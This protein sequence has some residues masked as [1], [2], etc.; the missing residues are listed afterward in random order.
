MGLIAEPANVRRRPGAPGQPDMP[1]A[2]LFVDLVGYSSRPI[3]EQVELKLVVNGLVARA[4]SDDAPGR[5]LA[6]DTGDG[7]ALCFLGDPLDAFHATLRLRQ[8]PVGRHGL[9]LPLRMG[10][11]HGPVRLVPDVNGH[12]SV[13][14]DGMNV[15]QRIMAMARPDEV[16][17]TRAYLEAIG[18]LAGGTSSGFRLVGSR[19]DKH[20]R[21]HEVHALV[22]AMPPGREPAPDLGLDPDLSLDWLSPAP[23]GRHRW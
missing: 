22:D 11:N 13:I 20:G 2:I 9:R 6:I 16:L 7:A 23:P 12:P 18:A 5:R 4:L 19:Q 1:C 8:L 21:P 15:A 17:A 14:G 10:L 3:D